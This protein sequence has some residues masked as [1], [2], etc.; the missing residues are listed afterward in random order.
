VH[1]PA[2][3]SIGNSHSIPSFVHWIIS[4]K[5]FRGGCSVT[6]AISFANSRSQIVGEDTK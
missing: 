2:S 6:A 1:I 5:P 4:S 3:L